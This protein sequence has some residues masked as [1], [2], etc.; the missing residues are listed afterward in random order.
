MP[1]FK[2]EPL[3]ADEANA[4][5]NACETTR[6]KLIIWTLLD[7]GLR[8]HELVNLKAENIDWQRHEL[9][10][11]GKGRRDNGKLR[12]KRRIVPMPPRTAALLENWFALT[13]RGEP[14]KETIG[15]GIRGAEM[16]VKRVANRAKISRPCT[17]HVLRHTFSVGCISKGISFPSL[18]AILGHDHLST[19]FIYSNMQPEVALEEFKRKF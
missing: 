7:T 14:G 18:Q 9:I 17:P 11:H 6:E 16:L 2:R 4:L 19:T 13:T 5:A 12:K 8:I 10:I 1:T 15:I 3:T